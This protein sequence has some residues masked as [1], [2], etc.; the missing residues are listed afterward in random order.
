MKN[1]KVNKFDQEHFK[2]VTS[3]IHENSE[4]PNEQLLKKFNS[5]LNGLSESQVG[6]NLSTYGNNDTRSRKEPPV[7]V[8]FCKAFINP[9]VFV[10]VIIAIISY[11]TGACW[12]FVPPSQQSWSQINIILFLIV[13]GGVIQFT[14]EYRSGKAAKALENFVKNTCLV[15][16]NNNNFEQMETK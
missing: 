7:I 11:L 14:Q 10:L 8:Q 12:L 2:N 1:K 15:K 13:V 9:F 3:K 6:K 16:R 4:I 5:S